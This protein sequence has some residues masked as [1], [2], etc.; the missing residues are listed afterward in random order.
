VAASVGLETVYIVR[1]MTNAAAAAAPLE[2]AQSYSIDLRLTTEG[3]IVDFL[4]PE[5]SRPNTPEERVRQVFA[6]KLHFDYGYPKHLMAIEVPINIG[7]ERRAA[8]IALF[9]DEVAAQI[10]DQGKIMPIPSWCERC[11]ALL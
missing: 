10:R 8:D 11:L 9:V 3:R 4:K 5:V 6:R 2:A 7:H 1:P